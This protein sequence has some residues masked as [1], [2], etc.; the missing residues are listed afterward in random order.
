MGEL[1]EE[2]IEITIVPINGSFGFHLLSRQ[3]EGTNKFLST[4]HS[5]LEGL[6]LLTSIVVVVIYRL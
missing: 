5:V 3:V 6:L 1:R 2:R 4:V